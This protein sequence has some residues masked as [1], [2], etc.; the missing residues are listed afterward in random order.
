MPGTEEA[1]ISLVSKEFGGASVR[2]KEDDAHLSFT[3]GALKRVNLVGPLYA[4]APTTLTKLS[5]VIAFVLRGCRKEKLSAIA[6]PPTTK[7]EEALRLWPDNP[8][9]FVLRCKLLVR[10]GSRELFTQ[11]LAKY[12]RYSFSHRAMI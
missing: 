4:G 7:T 10:I 2:A 11:E 12:D 9:A 1:V 3:F 6:P 5:R 8:I